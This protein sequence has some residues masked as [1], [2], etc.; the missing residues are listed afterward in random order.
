MSNLRSELIQERDH[1]K[2][3]SPE[4]VKNIQRIIDYIDD[5]AEDLHKERIHRI[6]DVQSLQL[7]NETMLNCLSGIFKYYK[8]TL[9]CSTDK[10][11]VF[12]NRVDCC[13]DPEYII[14]KEIGEI[15]GY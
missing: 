11:Q 15:L 8:S 5:L 6:S 14:Y 10:N 3:N 7:K 2:N 13:T 9:R 12:C 1:Y 4:K